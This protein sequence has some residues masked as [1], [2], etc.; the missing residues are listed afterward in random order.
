[1]D[2]DRVGARA[3]IQKGMGGDKWK[4]CGLEEV[5]ETVGRLEEE[6]CTFGGDTGG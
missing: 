2:G 6:K 1:M 4:L 3:E 5:D